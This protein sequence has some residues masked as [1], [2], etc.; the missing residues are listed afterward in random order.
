VFISHTQDDR[1][2]AKELSHE[3]LAK[4]VSASGAWDLPAGVPIEEQLQETIGEADVYV[5]LLSDRTLLSPWI[6]FELGAAVGGRKRL[7]L[8]FLSDRA[9]LDAPPSLRR[10]GVAIDAKSLRPGEVADRI[11]DLAFETP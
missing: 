3:L 7:F 6:L 4:G 5:T 8:V 2:F 10:R 1:E 11:V 9:A